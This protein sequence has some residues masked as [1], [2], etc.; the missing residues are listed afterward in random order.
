M[1]LLFR[2]SPHVTTPKPLHCHRY[3]NRYTYQSP[4]GFDVLLI[5]CPIKGP[6]HIRLLYHHLLSPSLPKAERDITLSTFVP[7]DRDKPVTLLQNRPGNRCYHDASSQCG[8]MRSK[9][10]PCTIPAVN[11]LP[12]FPIGG[13]D[14][15]FVGVRCY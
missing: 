3:M 10:L 14:E 5:M 8:R 6:G 2:R 11:D 13:A 12:P 1:I 4:S 7:Q 15:Q 9:F